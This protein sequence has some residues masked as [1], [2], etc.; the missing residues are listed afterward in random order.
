MYLIYNECSRNISVGLTSLLRNIGK[1]R[2]QGRK[3]SLKDFL[4][5]SKRNIFSCFLKYK[6][7]DFLTPSRLS[8]ACQLLLT[9]YY[10]SNP[11]QLRSTQEHRNKTNYFNWKVNKFN[12][13]RLTWVQEKAGI[14]E[15][16]FP[17]SSCGT[18]GFA[19]K[20]QS[21]CQRLDS[22]QRTPQKQ[23]QTPEGKTLSLGLMSQKCIGFLGNRQ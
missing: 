1:D 7:Q 20:G 10:T 4:Q 8:E 22:C 3:A 2:F 6:I 13:N 23:A 15:M 18:Q 19:T 21:H 9:N 12:R 14:T 11:Y 5:D 17:G 16:T